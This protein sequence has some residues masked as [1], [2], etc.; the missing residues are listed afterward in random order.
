MPNNLILR[1]IDPAQLRDDITASVVAALIPLIAKANEPQLVDGGRMAEIAGISRPTID[2]GVRDG[3]IPSIKIG[4][5]RLFEPRAVIDAWSKANEKATGTSGG[6]ESA[7][8]HD[9]AEGSQP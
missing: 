9:Q 2:R 7:S 5:R 4:R 3:I 1:D 8:E 6:Q